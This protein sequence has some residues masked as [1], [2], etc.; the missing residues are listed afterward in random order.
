M[1]TQPEWSCR[2]NFAAAG[3]SRQI[4]PIDEFECRHCLSSFDDKVRRQRGEQRSDVGPRSPAEF[5]GILG[6]L[7]PKWSGRINQTEMAPERRV[8]PAQQS[9]IGIH[10][11]NLWRP[12]S[13][14]MDA[15]LAIEYSRHVGKLGL[16]H[17][18]AHNPTILAST[19]ARTE[20]MCRASRKYQELARRPV[21]G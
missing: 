10:D 2:W 1:R 5:V 9:N 3:S 20:K 4:H 14:E 19:F 8:N 18:I 11:D 15:A 17:G 21:I 6:P 13:R 12:G 7:S 16:C